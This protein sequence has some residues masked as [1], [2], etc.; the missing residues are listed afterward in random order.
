MFMKKR[1][2][3]TQAAVGIIWEQKR[4]KSIGED[5]PLTVEEHREIMRMES[6]AS[7]MEIQRLRT[8]HAEHELNVRR[9]SKS[10]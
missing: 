6:E 7:R 9:E 5:R 10:V 4:E 8:A 3:R 2:T 1:H